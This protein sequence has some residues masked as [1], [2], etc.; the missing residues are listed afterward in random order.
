MPLIDQYILLWHDVYYLPWQ[1]WQIVMIVVI[2]LAMMMMQ[3]SHW[4]IYNYHCLV[5]E[6]S[7]RLLLEKKETETK[8]KPCSHC[9]HHRRHRHRHH[10]RGVVWW[11]WAMN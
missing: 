3:T 8:D 9:G 4:M 10:H 11:W 1:R 2:R 7:S 6:M 5:M